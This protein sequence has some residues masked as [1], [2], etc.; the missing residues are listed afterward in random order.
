MITLNDGFEMPQ[1]GFGVFK[2]PPDEVVDAVL[3]AI[4]AGYRLIDTAAVYRNEEGV[5]QAIADAPVARDDLFLTTKVWNSDQGYDATMRAFD[6]S[7]AKL[8]LETVDLYLIHWPLPG[9]DLYVDTWRALEQLKADGRTRSIGVSNFQIEHL[10]RL[11]TESSVVPAVNQI[12][13][14]PGLDQDDL[15]AF[16]ADHGIATEAWGPLGQ[17]KGLLDQAAVVDVAARK[18]RTPAQVVLRWSIQLGN[19]VIPKSGRPERMDEN[20]DLFDFELSSD[21]LAV[22]SALEDIGRLGP[23]P[24]TFD[25][26]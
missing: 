8:G 17:G 10:E 20:L 2:V 25:V 21:E 11:V 4:H 3:A 14:H 13:L 6:T 1:V 23:D 24:D 15:R 26:A 7:L 12:E 5:G 18:G 22:L 19:I 9:R 16:H